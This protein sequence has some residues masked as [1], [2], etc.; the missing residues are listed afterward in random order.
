MATHE[1]GC[2]GAYCRTCKALAAGACRGCKTGYESEE[3]DLSRARCRIK[4]CCIGRDFASCADCPDLSVCETIL[5]FHSKSGYKY[6]KYRDAIAFILE[7]GYD[8]F[9]SIADTWTNATG[10]Y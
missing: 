4:V 1:L 10:K 9:F 7:H 3:R 2:C 8:R 6:A 5:A